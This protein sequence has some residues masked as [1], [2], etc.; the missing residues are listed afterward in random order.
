MKRKTQF[1]KYWFHKFKIRKERIKN[2][3]WLAE[4][5]KISSIC[6]HN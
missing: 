6:L 5:N 1:I 2:K 4:K 3:N